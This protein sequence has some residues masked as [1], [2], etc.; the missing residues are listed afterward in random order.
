MKNQWTIYKNHQAI[1]QA[2][3][4]HKALDILVKQEGINGFHVNIYN[5]YIFINEH[6]AITNPPPKIH[7]RIIKEL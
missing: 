3:T 6:T 7:Y 4:W 5:Q 1:G 2:V